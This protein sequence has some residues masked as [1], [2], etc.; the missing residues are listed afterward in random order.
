MPSSS[1]AVARADARP[2]IASSA[3]S[4]GEPIRL[5]YGE[6]G[7]CPEARVGHGTGTLWLRAPGA[8]HRRKVSAPPRC[9]RPGAVPLRDPWRRRGTVAGR[10]AARHPELGAGRPN[11]SP[12]HPVASLRGRKRA[13]FP[14]RPLYVPSRTPHAHAWARCPCAMRCA[15]KYACVAYKRVAGRS[16]ARRK[17]RHEFHRRHDSV[18]A[19]PAT[20]VLEA[21]R[22]TPAGQPA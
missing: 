15:A 19:P 1:R 22:H 20:H 18:L 16:D 10:P 2:T 7:V 9:T 8:A 13:L 4:L 21:I 11:R 14:R 17:P 6:R 3:E 5:T 12:G